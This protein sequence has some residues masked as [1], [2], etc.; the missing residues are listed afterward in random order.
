MKIALATR[1][2][3]LAL[4]QAHL[5]QAECTR[6]FPNGE[7]E[8]KIIRTTGDKLQTASLANPDASLPRGLFTKELE[9]ALLQDEA[10]LAI[11]S[12][13]DLP[14]ELAPSLQLSATLPRADVRD[15]L[16][17]KES[18]LLRTDAA[19]LTLQNLPR[20]ARLGT[21]SNRRAAQIAACRKDLQAVTIR[22]NV[23]TRLQKLSS[24]AELDGILLA[25][26]GLHRLGMSIAPGGELKGEA[27]PSGLKAT[28]L[29]LEEMIP[30]VG[31]GAI[32]VE[33]RRQMSP[34]VQE[35]CGALNHEATFQCVSAERAFLRAVGGGCQSPVAAH[36][37]LREG[38]LE[39][40]VI[41]F[42]NNEVKRA[43]RRGT[44]EEA[45]QMGEQLAAEILGET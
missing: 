2:S 1:G 32:G 42:M 6:C 24:H 13:K 4:A 33:T 17:Y 40:R 41:S 45:V 37:Q 34:V 21:S 12:L 43:Q 22:G 31:Q 28:L 11:H 5:V 15:V 7:F 44:P 20:N 3:P 10:Q 30:A 36:A 19:E 26:A 38:A 23:G 35:L 29:S 27:V 25:A 8:L 39:L 18:L 16:I 14:T 9:V